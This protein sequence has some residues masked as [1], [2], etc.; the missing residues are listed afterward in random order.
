MRPM[1]AED[2]DQVRDLLNGFLFLNAKVFQFWSFDEVKHSFMAPIMHSYVVEEHGRITDLFSFYC[3]PTTIL[4]D[5]VHKQILQA[6]SF[7]NIS[8]TMR[9]EEGL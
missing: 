6:Y 3:M 7:Y 1:A 8:A 4:K 2:V 5:C 9:I